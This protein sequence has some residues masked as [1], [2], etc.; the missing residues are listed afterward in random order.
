MTFQLVA[1]D[2]DGTLLR[3][4]GTLSARNIAALH[5]VRAAGLQVVIVTGRPPRWVD[6]I[7]DQ[8]DLD[9][10]AICANGALVY[11]LATRRVVAEHLLASEVAQRL[12]E[13]LRASLPGVVFGYERASGLV[14]EPDFR[15]RRW[16]PTGATRQGADGMLATPVAKLLATHPDCEYADLLAAAVAAAGSD[17]VVTNAGDDGMVEISAAGVTKAFGVE[18]LCADLGIS[19][20]QVL[21]IGDMPNDVVLLRWAGH[22]VAVAGAHPDVVAVADEVTK[23]NDDDGVAEVLERLLGEGTYRRNPNGPRHRRNLGARRL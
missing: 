17:A 21:A 2:L 23:S 22:A 19:A 13:S 5:A 10:V 12:V 16:S 14:L 20:G 3:S 6:D 8:L 4:D 15:T 9:G 11:D 18:A 1:C 7:A